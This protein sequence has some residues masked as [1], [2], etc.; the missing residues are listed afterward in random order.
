[1]NHSGNYFGFVRVFV[2]VGAFILLLAGSQTFLYLFL[3]PKAQRVLDLTKVYI[4]GVESWNAIYILHN[5]FFETLLWN[6]TLNMWGSGDSLSVYM[7]QRKYFK[8]KIIAN[9]TDSLTYD[10]GNF[11]DSYRDALTKVRSHKISVHLV[12][13]HSF[14]ASKVFIH[15]SFLLNF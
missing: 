5:A 2:I 10:L 7:K 3:A 8:E 13:I 1:M 12:S 14:S 6:N 15:S 9:F 11:T 4:L